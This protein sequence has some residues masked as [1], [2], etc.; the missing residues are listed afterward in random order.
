M[1][2]F[3]WIAIVLLVVG[4]LA[5]AKILT[6]PKEETGP[7][8]GGARKGR[9]GGKVSASIY[10]VTQKPMQDRIIASGTVAANADIELRC[11]AAGRI[12]EIAFKEGSVV[13]KGQ[14]LLKLNDADLQAQLAKAQ[15]SLSLA[16]ERSTRQKSLLD[17]QMVSR[18][19]YDAATRDLSSAQAD[20]QL[21]AAQI[22]KTEVRAP[23]DGTIGL[24]SVDVGGYVSIGAKIANLVALRPLRIEFSVPE[25][26]AGIVAPGDS[27]AFRVE[28]SARSYPATVSAVEPK[29][30]ESTRTV[31]VRAVCKDPD[32]K[33]VPG[34]FAKVEMSLG[35]KSHALMV[36]SEALVGG[37]AGYSV[38]LVKNGT[39]ETRAVT[40][41]IR[42]ERNV[43]ILDGLAEGDSVMTTGLLSVRPGAQVD[44]R[45]GGDESS[46]KARRSDIGDSVSAQPSRAKAGSRP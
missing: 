44:A 8:T 7:Q 29:I 10:V 37:I 14:V 42:D 11:E 43:E 15:S 40:T 46:G 27:V 45:S 3:A 26:L 19:A 20:L 16:Q 33:V 5:A 38:F 30:D 1:K 41:G 28:G 2:K 18:D 31:R 4:I 17:D 35:K 12:T 13:K 6:M 32:K 22:T 39:A 36:P 21:V 23:F 24:R 25:R 9:G 34:A